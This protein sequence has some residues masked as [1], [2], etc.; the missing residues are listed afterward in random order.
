[1]F[2]VFI[3]CIVNIVLILMIV[4]F[5]IN[6]CEVAFCGLNVVHSRY[7]EILLVIE[8]YLCLKIKVFMDN[9]R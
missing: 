1:M 7:I 4:L 6:V 3:T 9:M 5:K 8:E 2:A